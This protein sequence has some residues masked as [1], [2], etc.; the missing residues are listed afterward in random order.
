MATA[1]EEI[2]PAAPNDIAGI[3]E[4][5]AE[6]VI[7]RGGLLSV[8]FSRE[9]FEKA[10]TEMPVIV[11]RRDGRVIG[12]VVSSSLAAQAHVPIV[13]AMLC[14]YRG[15]A[16]AYLY[17]PIC[18]AQN[19]RGHGLATRLFAAIRRQLTGREG[20]LFIRR[21]NA[22]SSRAHAKMGLR[23]VAEFTYGGAPHVHERK[24]MKRGPKTK[25]WRSE[26]C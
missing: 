19:E 24:T 20:I 7:D 3:L 5:Q 12:Y 25:R 18:V 15:G 22:S 16:G 6:K 11:A 10:I 26:D 13:G 9:F 1:D 2:G 14:V 21:D 4:L 17:G 8:A 23:E